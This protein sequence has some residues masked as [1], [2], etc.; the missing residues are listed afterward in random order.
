MSPVS[1][2]RKQSMMRYARENIKRIPLDVQNDFYDSI[3]EH[4]QQRGEKVNEFIKRAIKTQMER[5]NAENETETDGTDDADDADD[6]DG[7]RRKCY[8]YSDIIWHWESAIDKALPVWHYIGNPEHVRELD[9][10][11]SAIRREVYTFPRTKK[12][13]AKIDKMIADLGA[14]IKDMR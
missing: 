3:K 8:S 6:D 2:K 4:A 14:K 11:L 12:Q 7:F 10:E 5:D 1:E 13:I 9:D